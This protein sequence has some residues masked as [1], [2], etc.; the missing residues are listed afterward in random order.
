[1]KLHCL[2]LFLLSALSFVSASTTEQVIMASISDDFIPKKHDRPSLADLLTIEPSASIFYSYAR[3]IALSRILD[4]TS[5]KYTLFV[6]TNKAVMALSRKPHQGPAH[7]HNGDD[8]KITEAQYDKQSKENVEQWISAHIISGFHMDFNSKEYQT[9]LDNKT[10]SVQPIPKNDGKG[11][12]WTR[13]TLDGKK[14]IKSMKEASNGI[15]YL[16]DGV[17]SPW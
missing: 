13:V 2:S 15:L 5:Q 9:L 4:D 12:A 3:E 10:I 16:L 17:I 8:V 11:P 14:H 1:M 6:P 7:D